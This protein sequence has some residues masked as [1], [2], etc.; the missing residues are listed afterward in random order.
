MEEREFRSTY[1][2]INPRECPFERA[3]LRRCAAC[4]EARRIY[5]AEREAIG[6]NHE[7]CFRQCSE[8]FEQALTN[9]R[10]ALKLLDRDEP[11]PH[12]KRIKVECGTLIGLHDLAGDAHTRQEAIDNVSAL[13]ADAVGRYG[14]IDA[15]P[16]QRLMPA[17][18]HFQGRSR[19]R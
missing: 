4:R 18:V 1:H 10:F 8:L 19:R 15:L 2:D 11:V 9:A 13:V 16:Y 5:L 3:I 17:I 7:G 12:G 14:S 6:C